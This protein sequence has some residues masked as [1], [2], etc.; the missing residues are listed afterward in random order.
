M[1][2]DLCV[3]KCRAHSVIAALLKHRRRIN[4]CPVFMGIREPPNGNFL[5]IHVVVF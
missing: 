4:F 1:T 3:I 2:H 5:H